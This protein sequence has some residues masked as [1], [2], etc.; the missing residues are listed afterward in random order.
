M[1]YNLSIFKTFKKP[2]VLILVGPPLCGKSTFCNEYMEKVDKDVVIISRDAIMLSLHHNDDYDQAYDAVNPKEINRV[3][4]EQIM[5]AAKNSKNVIMDMTHMVP[6][7][8]IGNIS[9]FSKKYFKAAVVFPFP[10]E[11]EIAIR[12]QK[13]ILNENKSISASTMKQ[14]LDIYRPVDKSEGFDKIVYL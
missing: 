8:R 9:Y 12:N 4:R 2:Y 1:G 7:R 5:D 6:K 3:L 10:T 13:R 11:E 14:M